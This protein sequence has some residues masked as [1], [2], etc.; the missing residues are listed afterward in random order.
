MVDAMAARPKRRRLLPPQS[1]TLDMYWTPR[2]ASAS[3]LS[4]D[5]QRG[6][7]PSGSLAVHAS[8]MAPL[9]AAPLRGHLREHDCIDLISSSASSAE[10]ACASDDVNPT[11]ADAA[12]TLTF[13]PA[14]S[15]ATP[16]PAPS[17]RGIPNAAAEPRMPT[18]EEL[19]KAVVARLRGRDSLSLTLKELRAELE[20]VFFLAEG[21]LYSRRRFIKA[22]AR[23]LLQL[24]D[25]AQEVWPQADL[26]DAGQLHPVG[27]LT[28]ETERARVAGH[29]DAIELEPAPASADAGPVARRALTLSPAQSSGARRPA[30]PSGT[31]LANASGGTALSWGQRDIDMLFC[32]VTIAASSAGMAARKPAVRHVSKPLSWNQTHINKM[33]GV[34]PKAVSDRA[35]VERVDEVCAGCGDRCW[36]RCGGFDTSA[37]VSEVAMDRGRLRQRRWRG[38]AT[39]ASGSS[40]EWSAHCARA[41]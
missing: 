12:R 25:N 39:S 23:E 4:P 27:R 5:V 28:G 26:V 15:V 22:C 32:R 17:L 3:Q 35:S 33:F 2:S 20:D 34:S 7:H 40:P 9:S 30:L 14:C 19:Q 24:E 21:A 41:R 29:A 8:P 16:R 37:L 18:A 1:T 31:A 36:E 38:R 6:L 11:T 10:P 13:S